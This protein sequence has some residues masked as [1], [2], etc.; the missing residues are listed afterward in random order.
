MDKAQESIPLQ[1]HKILV[2]NRGEIAMRIMRACRKLEW[3]LQPFSLLKMRLRAMCGWHA[4]KAEKKAFTACLL[5]TTPTNSWPWPMKRVAPLYIP[6]TV[7]L[8]RT[9]VLHAA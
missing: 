9:F 2:A 1:K 6:A 3:P 7:F 4:N 5:T 8:P